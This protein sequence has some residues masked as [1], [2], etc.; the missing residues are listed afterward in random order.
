MFSWLLKFFIC[1]MKLV[2]VLCWCRN[3][4]LCVLLVVIMLVV[5]CNWCLK[6]WCWVGCG[7][8]LWK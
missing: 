5:N 1:V 6:V 3:S 4:G 7:V 2:C 8:K